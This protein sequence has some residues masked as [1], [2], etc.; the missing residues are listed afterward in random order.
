MSVNE[1]KVAAAIQVLEHPTGGY[2]IRIGLDAMLEL[3]PIFEEEGSYSNGPAWGALL[4]YLMASDPRIADLKP[5]PEGLGWSA[6]REPLER[7]RAILLEAAAE[8]RLLRK[9][10]RDGRAA[11]FGYGDL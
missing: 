4:D 8:P 9:M 6:T 2:V 11:G 5:D 7:L 3:M 1:A 10:I